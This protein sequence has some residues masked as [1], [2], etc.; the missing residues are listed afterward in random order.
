MAAELW[1]SQEECRTAGRRD[2]DVVRRCALCCR[3][4]DQAGKVGGSPCQA[5]IESHNAQVRSVKETLQQHPRGP[6]P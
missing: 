3:A 4:V 2:F 6:E 5:N 1:T